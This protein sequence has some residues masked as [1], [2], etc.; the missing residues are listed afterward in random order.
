VEPHYNPTY[1]Y[2]HLPLPKTSGAIPPASIILISIHG[3]VLTHRW[4]FIPLHLPPP[5]ILNLVH[6]DMHALPI[7]NPNIK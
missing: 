1:L 5:P 3:M 6:D 4:N 2:I 7:W